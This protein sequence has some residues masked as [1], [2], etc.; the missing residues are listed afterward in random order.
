MT[1]NNKNCPQVEKWLK[2]SKNK[3]GGSN[4]KFQK[5]FICKTTSIITLF[6]LAQF[7]QKRH[8]FGK[9]PNQNLIFSWIIRGIDQLMLY[10]R[11]HYHLWKTPQQRNFQTKQKIL[12]LILQIQHLKQLILENKKNC[13]WSHFCIFDLAVFKTAWNWTNQFYWVKWLKY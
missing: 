4:Q 1:K 2:W 11:L 13:I 9:K 6:K 12:T 10:K 5:I 3:K 8:K 7:L